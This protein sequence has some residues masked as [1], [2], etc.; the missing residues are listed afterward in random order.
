M[1]SAAES[2]EWIAALRLLC[3]PAEG[4]EFTQIVNCL[5]LLA[6]GEIDPGGLLV[7]RKDG[8]IVGAQLSVPLP[9]FSG[10]VWP[11]RV[12][13]EE[14]PHLEDQLAAAGLAFLEGRRVKVVHAILVEEQAAASLM[15]A[16]L[17]PMTHLCNL[18][19]DLREVP[20]V[21]PMDW[22]LHPF[23]P[24][25]PAL[26]Q[27]TLSRTYEHTLDCPELNGTRTIEEIIVGHKAQGQFRPDL[28]RH[29]LVQDRPIGV[30]LINP[31]K[32][33]PAWDLSYLGVV[34]EERGRGYGTALASW[35]LRHAQSEGVTELQVAVDERN[36]H[37]LRLYRS[38]GFF[39]VNR[40][41][42]LWKRL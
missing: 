5:S 31:L 10:L 33:A 39:K 13:P 40:R 29:A 21:S 23:E 42:V 7:A 20:V 19:H 12:R 2:Y 15:R 8:E 32:D 37:A 25:R 28:W 9:G 35:A 30:I 38:L 1:I 11:P 41:F 27:E 6:T 34:P 4:V 3:A 18:Q 14:G 16:G 22:K 24:E 17:L 36:V 26:F